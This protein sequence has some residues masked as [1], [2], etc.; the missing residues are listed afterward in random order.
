LEL[1]LGHLGNCIRN[2]WEVLKC[3]AGEGRSIGPIT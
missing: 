3:S 2:T 1:K